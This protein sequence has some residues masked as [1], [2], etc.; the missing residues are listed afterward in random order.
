MKTKWFNQR[1]H[2]NLIRGATEK[3]IIIQV[4]ST[5]RLGRWKFY[6]PAKLTNIYT[7]ILEI[8]F[9]ETW[10]FTLYRGKERRN[11]SVEEFIEIMKTYGEP[12][13]KYSKGFREVEH[14]KKLTPV[15]RKEIPDELINS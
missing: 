7:T 15:A 2:E 12:E 1:F 14:P 4:P 11:L 10:E 5:C 6:H 9:P 3:A 13:P 8:R